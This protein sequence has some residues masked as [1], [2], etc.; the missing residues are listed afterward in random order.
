MSTEPVNPIDPKAFDI[1]LKSINE[2][3]L[4]MYEGLKIFFGDYKK[5]IKNLAITE[6]ALRKILF[7]CG[8]RFVLSADVNKEFMSDIEHLHVKI[9]MYPLENGYIKIWTE[10]KDD[11]AENETN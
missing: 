8:G 7:A 6:T 2:W 9:H 11:E 3:E 4:K 10:P 5:V 1:Y